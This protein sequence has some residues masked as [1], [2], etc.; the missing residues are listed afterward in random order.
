MSSERNPKINMQRPINVQNIYSVLANGENETVE[1]K[2]TIHNIAILGKIVSAFANA[3]GGNIIV[4]Y[5]EQNKKIIGISE[6]EQQKIKSFIERLNVQNLCTIYSFIIE[7]KALLVIEVQKT[8][9]TLQFYDGG[10]Y[11]RMSD[12]SNR[13]MTVSAKYSCGFPD[14][15]VLPI[16]VVERYLDYFTTIMEDRLWQV[17]AKPGFRWRNRSGLSMNAARVA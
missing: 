11:I 12:T 10:A 1:F 13:L 15:Q 16:I 17:L 9:G 14:P 2:K 6:I 7:D 4:G 8:D 5:D 3:N